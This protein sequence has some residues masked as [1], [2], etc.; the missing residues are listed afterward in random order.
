[1]TFKIIAN[2]KNIPS[3]T[4][5]TDNDKKMFRASEKYYTTDADFLEVKKSSRDRALEKL[6]ITDED[7]KNHAYILNEIGF[8]R[9]PVNKEATDMLGDLLGLRKPHARIQTQQAGKLVS[10]HLDDLKYGYM[11]PVENINSLYEMN[12]E[13]LSAFDNDPYYATRFLIL[14]EDAKEGQGIC[15][16]DQILSNWKAGD[17]VHWDW[18]NT[19]HSTFNTSYWDRH[20]IR[21]TGIVTDKTNSILNGDKA[22]LDYNNI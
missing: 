1:M 3:I 7:V 13:E 21:L 2:I 5:M 10:I 9:I 20:L 12:D 22:L 6:N 19:V 15:F 4:D 11:S 8:D 18:V 16:A 17:V 14:L